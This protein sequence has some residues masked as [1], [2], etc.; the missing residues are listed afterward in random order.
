MGNSLPAGAVLVSGSLPPAL[1]PGAS[2]VSGDIPKPPPQMNRYSAP[3]QGLQDFLSGSTE[4][5]RFL[6][7]FP[8]AKKV[9]NYKAP[10]SAAANADIETPAQQTQKQTA[11]AKKTMEATGAASGAIVAAPIAAAVELPLAAGLLGE[12]FYTALGAG[13]GTAAA[14]AGMG[15]NPTTKENLETSGTNALEAGGGTLALGGAFRAGKL[16]TDLIKANPG[17][18]ADLVLDE[19]P[20][21][22]TARKIAKL[23]NATGPISLP[24]GA[25]DTSAAEEAVTPFEGVGKPKPVEAPTV[26]RTPGQVAPER[27]GTASP[28]A[29]MP[30][31]SGN[32]AL[33]EGAVLVRPPKA[34][35]PAP[36]IP[37][38]VETHKPQYA[39]RVRTV[40]EEGVPAQ[41]NVPAHATTTLED[42]QRLAPGRED[43]T[44]KPQEIVRVPL[45]NPDNY[46]RIPRDNGPD[47]IKFKKPVPES[48]VEPATPQKAPKIEDV[49]R[50]AAG[51]PPPLKP[52]VPIGQQVARSTPT[53]P[54]KAFGSTVAPEVSEVTGARTVAPEKVTPEFAK[55]VGKTTGAPSPQPGKTLRESIANPNAPTEETPAERLRRIYPD[56]GAR[57]QVHIVGEDFYEAAKAKPD[58][59]K[60]GTKLSGPDVAN[61]AINLGEDLGQTRVGSQKAKYVAEGAQVK[62]QELLS[63]LIKKGYTPEE[64][65]A[66]AKKTGTLSQMARP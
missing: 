46:T 6:Q 31:A 9:S 24:S 39:Y 65:I 13:G 2:L 1:P 32:I 63:R 48:V 54:G 61:A 16:A 40:G 38:M 58:I 60:A 20:A 37:D 34:L 21:L 36:E 43:I 29:A 57:Q 8:E 66:A 52:N 26:R 59:L 41:Q 47:W 42:A 25:F 50:Q 64:I 35:P 12:A 15:E 28:A 7:Q 51:S 30:A 53:L 27:V 11:A 3:G 22:K 4:E 55:E 17:A 10:A 19:I 23:P 5:Q 49:V 14:Q 18:A 56:S 44:G 62:P 33:P 45:N